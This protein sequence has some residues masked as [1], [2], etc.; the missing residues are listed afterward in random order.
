LPCGGNIRKKEIENDAKIYP[1][2]MKR[3]NALAH[4]PMCRKPISEED[5]RYL[6]KWIIEAENQKQENEEQEEIP[7][8]KVEL[9]Q[10]QKDQQKKFQELFQRQ[11]TNEGII[12]TE[13]TA[14][15]STIVVNNLENRIAQL[16]NEQASE[17]AIKEIEETTEIASES[18]T[19]N[20]MANPSSSTGSKKTL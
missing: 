3:D 17:A 18:S 8:V 12:G 4:C 19:S 1:I 14:N 7:Y 6:E 15:D 10:E 20:S 13:S 2:F 11:V 16:L 9:T 5:M